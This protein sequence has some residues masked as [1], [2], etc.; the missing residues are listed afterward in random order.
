MKWRQ[1]GGQF[2]DPKD[3]TTQHLFYTVR[4]IYTHTYKTNTPNIY[5][6]DPD[7]YPPSYIAAIT[8]ILLATLSQRTI[9]SAMKKELDQ[10][11]WNN[12]DIVTP[13]PSTKDKARTT[14]TQTSTR[15]ASP[16]ATHTFW[17]S[18]ASW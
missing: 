10:M 17:S 13:L 16:T 15:S 6:F 1:R 7:L 12:A 4:M 2:I 14:S 8:P 11:D 18:T 9:P 5:T 3:M